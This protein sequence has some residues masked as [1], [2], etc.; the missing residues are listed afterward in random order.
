MIDILMTVG[1]SYALVVLVKYLYMTWVLGIS[2]DEVL[3]MLNGD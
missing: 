1:Y 2:K 3:N